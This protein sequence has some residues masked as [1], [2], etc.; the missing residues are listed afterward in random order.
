MRKE[1]KPSFLYGVSVE[2]DN[3]TDRTQESRRLK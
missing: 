1:V 2:G 3:F